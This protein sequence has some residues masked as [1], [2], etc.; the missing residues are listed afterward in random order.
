MYKI[1]IYIGFPFITN[2]SL[3]DISCRGKATHCAHILNIWHDRA[4]ITLTVHL[5]VILFK[6]A[7]SEIYANINQNKSTCR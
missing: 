5:H 1:T 6:H 3:H 2:I 7:E 4:F